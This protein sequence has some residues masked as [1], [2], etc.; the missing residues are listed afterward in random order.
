M[1]ESTDI[2]YMELNEM[3]QFIKSKWQTVAVFVLVF[4]TLAFVFSVVQ[5]QKYRSEQRFLAVSRYAED[6]DPYAATRSTEHLTNL[7]SEVMYS[8]RFMDEVLSAGF[9]LDENVFP[10]SPKK[11]KKA[12]QKTLS[13]RVLGDTGILDVAIFH[14]DQFVTEQLAMAVGHVLRTKHSEYHS[15]GN[16]LTIQTID[17]PLTSLRPVQPNIPLNTA[18]G[19]A[20]GLVASLA[21]IYLFPRKEFSFAENRGHRLVGA[22]EPDWSKP[23]AVP[24]QVFEH[25]PIP[26]SVYESSEVKYPLRGSGTKSADSNY[27]MPYNE[28]PV[29]LPIA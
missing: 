1:F 29:N 28:P 17:Q 8:Q 15:R 21:F 18:A 24:N 9:A 7:L 4:T 16:A 12:W 25:E 2:I 5:P 22:T 26:I 6:V 19:F 3:T 20:L 27:E 13:T 11:R 23:I 10:E 14:K